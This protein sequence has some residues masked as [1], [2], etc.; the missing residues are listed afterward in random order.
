MDPADY[1]KESCND[2]C[3]GE[4]GE[5]ASEYGMCKCK[6]YKTFKEQC[7]QTCIDNS[8]VSKIGR[9]VDGTLQLIF[10]DKSG[11]TTKV[12]ILSELGL[13]DYD[14]S[15]RGCRF[16]EQKIDGMYGFH[17]KETSQAL[18]FAS[19]GSSR[20]KRAVST[21]APVTIRS[22]VICVSIGQVV[23]FKLNLNP[24]NRSLSNYPQYRK[25]HLFNTNPDF[26]YGNFRQLHSIIQTTNQTVSIFAQVFTEPGVHVFYDN[27]V[28]ARE[29]IVMV[30]QLGSECPKNLTMDASL[31]STLTTAKVTKQEVS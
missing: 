17:P 6:S 28:P 23:V 12:N 29:T 15:E 8:P 26:D 13:P 3:G 31:S 2:Y 10:T 1:A 9:S 7:D 11:K 20:K 5:F 16:V 18:G 4:G 25:N 21:P 24:T 14:R 27:A 22:P 19:T 30:P